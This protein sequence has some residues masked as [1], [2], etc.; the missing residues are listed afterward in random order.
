MYQNKISHT[1]E[2]QHDEVDDVESKLLMKINLIDE[3][4]VVVD[5]VL[6]E[7]RNRTLCCSREKIKFNDEVDDQQI[8]LMLL[9]DVNVEMLTKI[10]LIGV[11]GDDFGDVPD[12]VNERN[13]TL[14]PKR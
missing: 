1:E 12:N 5:Y 3:V 14:F 7:Q 13:Q 2:V 9:K 11:A 6:N 4:V 10:N 8:Q